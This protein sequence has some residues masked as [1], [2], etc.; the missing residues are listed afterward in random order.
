LPVVEP[1]RSELIGRI[2]NI[3][4]E[5]YDEQ[6]WVWSLI[7]RDYYPRELLFTDQWPYGG[8]TGW[9]DTDAWKAVPLDYSDDSIPLESAEECAQNLLR[10]YPDLTR[11]EGISK[12]RLERLRAQWKL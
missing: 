5:D 6:D 4:D 9:N 2:E 10:R 11:I 3:G 7:R 12:E 8:E 1:L